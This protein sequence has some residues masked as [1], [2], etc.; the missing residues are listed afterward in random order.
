VQHGLLSHAKQ[1][2]TVEQI[3]EGYGLG[4]T[5]SLLTLLH[6]D[7]IPGGVATGQQ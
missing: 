6:H 5:Y 1:R 2:A 7:D 3:Q 4:L